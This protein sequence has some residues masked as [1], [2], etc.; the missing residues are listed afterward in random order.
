[1]Q[2]KN[3]PGKEQKKQNNKRGIVLLYFLTTNKKYKTTYKARKTYEARIY[4]KIDVKKH[5]MKILGK[6]TITLFSI[7]FLIF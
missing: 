5:N 7:L 6:D 2:I 1:M 4:N 3:N